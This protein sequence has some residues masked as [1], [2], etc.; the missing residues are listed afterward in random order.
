MKL[1]FLLDLEQILTSVNME[2]FQNDHKTLFFLLQQ[3]FEFLEFV[4][5]D[6]QKLWFIGSVTKTFIIIIIFECKNHFPWRQTAEFHETAYDA[7]ME[8][9]LLR[10][11]SVCGPS[12]WH[13]NGNVSPGG[14]GWRPLTYNPLQ[15]RINIFKRSQ[16]K[17]SKNVDW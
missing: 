7:F 16:L 17:P 1:N 4:A 5:T 14:T 2:I 9:T 3:N 6:R 13:Y 12:L 8:P 11:G 15:G 10:T